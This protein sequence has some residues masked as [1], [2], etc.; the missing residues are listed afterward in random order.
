MKCRGFSFLLLTGITLAA[1][2]RAQTFSVLHSFS[3]N[4]DGANPYSGLIRDSGG[5]LYGTTLAGGTFYSGAAFKVDSKGDETVLYSFGS[6][7]GGAGPLGV[8]EDVAGNL[9]GTS[10]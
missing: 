9:C 8:I 5:N 10:L 2:A 1:A 3:G 7:F 6:G 4:P